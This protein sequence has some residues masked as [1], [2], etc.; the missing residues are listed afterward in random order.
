MSSFVVNHVTPT[1]LD[2]DDA[3][4]VQLDLVRH[5]RSFRQRFR[6]EEQHSITEAHFDGH[7]ERPL[8]SS[9]VIVQT[10][11]FVDA[12]RPDD[13]APAEIP[14]TGRHRLSWVDSPAPRLRIQCDALRTYDDA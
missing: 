11:V 8:Q 1:R 2:R 13:D 6:V 4:P 7:A 9:N 14:G 12:A 3:L 10:G 5:N